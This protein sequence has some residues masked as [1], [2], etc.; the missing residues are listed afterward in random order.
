MSR[1]PKLTLVSESVYRLDRPPESTAEKVK[2]RQ[3][4]AK[5]LAREHIEELRRALENAS[6]MAA[7]VAAGGDAYQPGARDLAQRMVD[8]I[9][10][11]LETLEAVMSKAPEP[12]L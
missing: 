4:E 7:L 2:L 3:F 11:Q 12:K 5:M 1:P 9:T 10:S 8:H 6:A